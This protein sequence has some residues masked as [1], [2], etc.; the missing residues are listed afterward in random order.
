LFIDARRPQ[1]MHAFPKRI[2]RRISA[3]RWPRKDHRLFRTVGRLAAWRARQR[4][5]SAPVHQDRPAGSPPPALSR[6][7][8]VRREGAVLHLELRVDCAAAV[9]RPP[10]LA[11]DGAGAAAAG[12]TSER[13]PH[14]ASRTWT[15]SL[16]LN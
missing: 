8:G 14:V 12:A 16:L 6:I 9:G 2:R 7:V 11:R 15:V 3:P 1:D 5:T 10:V 13:L 4:P